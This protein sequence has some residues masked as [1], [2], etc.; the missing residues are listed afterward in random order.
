MNICLLSS[1]FLPLVGGLEII[2]HNLATALSL[3]GHNVYVVTPKTK[4]KITKLNESYNVIRFGFKGY[5][6]LKLFHIMAILSLTYVTMKYK[7]DVIN[8]HNVYCAGTWA[9]YFKLFNNSIPIIGTPHGDDVQ[10][11]YEIEDG[12]RLNPKSNKIVRRN[13]N[14]CT[15]VTSI[16]NSIRT[17]LCELIDDRSKIIDVPNGIWSGIYEKKVNV[18]IVRK[19]YNISKDSIAIISV[20]RNHPRKGF[21]YGLQAISILKQKGYDIT[22]I[23]VG[24]DM[25]SLRL[26]A[27][28]YEI[29]DSIVITNEVNSDD[30]IDLYRISD[31]Y[32]SPSIIESFGVATLEAMSAGLPCVVTNVQG[33]RDIVKPEYGFLIKSKDSHGMSNALEYLIKNHDIRKKMGHKAANI[34]RNY[35]WS[36]IAQ[37]YIK[38]YKLA[39]EY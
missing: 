11:N 3:D 16:S 20:G 12:V 39:L 14:N 17:D 4:I 31:I 6:R 37:K 33:S 2:V 25:E 28:N 38:V 21:E 26:K 13:I 22:Y 15:L 1:T 18:D 19:K 8:V 23:L 10:M 7:I 9:Y 34:A 32:L 29:S 30:I 36:N 24:R 35:N 27:E 5:G